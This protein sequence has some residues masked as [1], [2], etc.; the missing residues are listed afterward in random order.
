MRD[1]DIVEY[2]K[3][4]FTQPTDNRRFLDS[5]SRSLNLAT[6]STDVEGQAT[7]GNVTTA[8]KK[9]PNRL[10]LTGKLHLGTWDVHDLKKLVIWLLLKGSLYNIKSR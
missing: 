5:G 7:C 6:G 3:N 1:E 8:S 4:I 9:S 2:C 10:Q